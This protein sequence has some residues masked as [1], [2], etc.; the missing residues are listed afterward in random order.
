MRPFLIVMLTACNFFT[1]V[2]LCRAEVRLLVEDAISRGVP[3][4]NSGQYIAC[5]EI[6]RLCL[7]SLQLL[8]TEDLPR[9][10]IE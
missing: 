7:R 4:Y 10:T 3:L 5:A 2:D 1:N 6:Y 8:S 9:T